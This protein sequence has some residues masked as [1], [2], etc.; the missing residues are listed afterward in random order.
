MLNETDK[1]NPLFK[2]YNAEYRVRDLSSKYKNTYIVGVN[3]C[4]R[5]IYN[6]KFYMTLVVAKSKAEA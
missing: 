6:P 3:A 1:L 5:E 2:L 4:C